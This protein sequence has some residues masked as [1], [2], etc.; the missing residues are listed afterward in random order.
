[1]MFAKFLTQCQVETPQ[2]WLLLLDYPEAPLCPDILKRHKCITL[3]NRF[4]S[5]M[6][7]SDLEDFQSVQLEYVSSR[8]NYYISLGLSFSSVGEFQLASV[9]LI[10]SITHYI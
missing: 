4:K 7:L 10:S 3:H 6:V 9:C 1:M 2:M 5:K 8:V